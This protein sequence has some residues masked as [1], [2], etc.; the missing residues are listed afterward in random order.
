MTDGSAQTRS[1]HFAEDATARTYSQIHLP[2]IFA[3]WAR[4]LLEVVPARAGETVLDVAT[5]PGTVAREAARL[6][7]PTGRVVG[8]D[9]SAAMLG[10]GRGWPA[11]AGSAQIEYVEAS[12]TAMPLPDGSFDVAYCQQGLQHVSDADAALREIYR[13]L[14]VG[15]R[16]GVAT[17]QRSPFSLFREVVVRLGDASDGIQPSA[18]GRDAGE[19]RE[20][21]RGA[22]FAAVQIQT[23]EL[24]SVL[25][26]GIPQALELAVATSAASGLR[27]M[28]PERQ[29]A[30][31]EAIA[32]AL[33]PYVRDGAV[34]LP[35]VTNLAAAVR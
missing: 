29:H 26:G 11:E 7:G 27:D 32:E 9:I 2:R 33:Q 10:V 17:W 6:A 22:G 1:P 24:E 12:A 31:R 4:I 34:V 14:K 16:V 18:F 19:L 25:E 21:L 8:V 23:R 3:P 30:I 5:G 28:S 20:A 35:S 15:G 13:L